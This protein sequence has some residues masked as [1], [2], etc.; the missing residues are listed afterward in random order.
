[1]GEIVMYDNAEPK[2]H[3][4]GYLAHNVTD[5]FGR[6]LLVEGA[7][8]TDNMI[9]K[10]KNRRIP[11][12]LSEENVSSNVDSLQHFRTNYSDSPFKVPEKIDKKFENFNLESVMNASKYLNIL[13][14]EM[15]ND[16]FLGNSLKALSQGQNATYSHS[17]NVAILSVAIAEKMKLS[18]TSL[19]EVSIGALLHDIGKM[20]LPPDV[21]REVSRMSDGQEMLYQQHPRIGADL[22]AADKLPLGIYLTVQQHHEKYSGGGYPYGIKED[23]I[24]INACIVS[25]ANVFDRVTTGIYQ[26][27]CLTPAEAIDRIRIGKGLDY[28]PLVVD[29]FV[30]LFKKVPQSC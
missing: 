18:Q 27:N 24:N 12:Q 16:S 8:M 15:R 19:Q 23:Q 11:F 10:L 22:L 9:Q 28:H 3:I 17:I 5:K 26:R 20:L 13:L 14:K 4:V 30:S 21:L 7:P 6:L 1:M 29:L 2:I 25:V